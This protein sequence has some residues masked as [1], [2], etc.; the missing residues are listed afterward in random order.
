LLHPA[1][2]P[3]EREALQRDYLERLLRLQAQ[4]LSGLGRTDEAGEALR[5]AERLAAEGRAGQ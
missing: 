4:A 1:T 5:A 2:P 3:A